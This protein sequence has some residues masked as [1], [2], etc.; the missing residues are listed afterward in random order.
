LTICGASSPD[1][2]NVVYGPTYATGFV[3]VW[4]GPASDQT[5]YELRPREHE[6]RAA[7]KSDLA[8]GIAW[9]MHADAL[10]GTGERR[11]VFEE[12]W[13]TSFP[14]PEATQH[15]VD[16]F[17]EGA[18]VARERYVHVDSRCDLPMPK[19][20]VKGEGPD[21]RIVELSITPWQRDFFRVLNALQ[22]AV[23]YD[24]YVSRA[25]LKVRDPAT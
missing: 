3:E 11:Q 5:G 1:D 18:L 22:T 17:F 9:G 20:K 6:A 13:A 23:D 24:S 7:F 2:W 10:T 4:N 12:E 21:A 16:F 15:F 19:R 8:I 25:G 14:D